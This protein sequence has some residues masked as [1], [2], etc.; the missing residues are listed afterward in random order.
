MW[1]DLAGASGM[2][3]SVQPPDGSLP[4]LVYV[5]DTS[6]SSVRTRVSTSNDGKVIMYGLLFTVEEQ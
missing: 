1:N 2:F 5:S 4:G 6:I 3:V